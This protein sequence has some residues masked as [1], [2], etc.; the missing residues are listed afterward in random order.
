MGGYLSCV[1][2]GDNGREG[3]E[4]G[5]RK[6]SSPTGGVTLTVDPCRRKWLCTH[7]MHRYVTHVR[8]EIYADQEL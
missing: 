1:Y 4:R 3:V 5:G 2:E 7:G 8:E 6:R